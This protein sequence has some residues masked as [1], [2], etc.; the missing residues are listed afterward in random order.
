MTRLILILLVLLAIAYA[1]HAR[2]RPPTIS[3]D[4]PRVVALI[5]A[6][7]RGNGKAVAKMAAAG[8]DLDARG[9]YG[10]TP[11]LWAVV[12]RDPKA[13]RTLLKAGA[14]P[15]LADGEGHVPLEWAVQYPN[16]VIMDLLLAHGADPNA[17]DHNGHPVT[18]DAVDR[19][20]WDHLDKLIAAGADME[21]TSRSG[22]TLLLYLAIFNQFDKVAEFIERG[23]DYTRT[24]HGTGLP[25]YVQENRIDPKSPNAIWRD[26]VKAM[27]EERGVLFPVP[28]PWEQP[29]RDV[30]PPAEPEGNAPG[31]V[32][33][34]PRVIALIEAAHRG[35]AKEVARLAGLG[36][37][38]NAKGRTGMTPVFW[39][40]VEQDG[41][42][43][44]T[45]LGAGANPDLPDD[46]DSRPIHWAVRAKELA[47]LKTL[48]ANGADPDARDFMGAPVLLDAIRRDAWTHVDLLL[49]A[50]ANPEAV[51]SSGTTPLL[52]LAEAGQFERVA[53]LIENHAGLD[54]R[55][56]DSLGRSIATFVQKNRAHPK[57]AEGIWRERL[58]AL[59]EERGI[60]FPAPRPKGK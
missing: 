24:S 12:E 59:L 57:S 25:Y 52:A 30:P 19:D 7:R 20:H 41:R 48:L 56:E 36:A 54:Y 40:T 60:S 51:S 45:L 16:P 3:F 28:R 4:D 38:I 10:M 47:I 11:V 49:K 26:R 23:A 1:V 29:H 31:E 44:E 22:D 32:F 53:R 5:E 46:Q 34:D 55:H 18:F 14:N 33:E 50:G 21:A 13:L 27:L 6:A 2:R 43:L 9:K 15:D 37:P 58:K 42:A 17:K 35:D 39:A 8:V